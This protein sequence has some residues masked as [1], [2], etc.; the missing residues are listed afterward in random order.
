LGRH[1]EL[2]ARGAALAAFRLA[3]MAPVMTMMMHD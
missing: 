1:F 2:H 3:A